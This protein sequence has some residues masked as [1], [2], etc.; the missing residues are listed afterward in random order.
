[1]PSGPTSHGPDKNEILLKRAQG[2]SDLAKLVANV[3]NY[4]FGSFFTNCLPQLEGEKVFG[5]IKR[6][7]DYPLGVDKDSHCPNRVNFF[8]PWVSILAIKLDIVEDVHV[9]QLPPIGSSDLLPLLSQGGLEL[10]ENI[11][12]DGY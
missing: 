2:S 8:H 10:K 9:Q 12:V 1:L 3:A 11:C 7:I 5:F 6:P 4:T